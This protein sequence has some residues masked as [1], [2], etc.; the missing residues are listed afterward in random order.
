MDGNVNKHV[1]IAS[2]KDGFINLG[3]NK[4]AR[5]SMNVIAKTLLIERLSG[6]PI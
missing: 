4:D 5:H 1:V 3:Y 2:M 6:V